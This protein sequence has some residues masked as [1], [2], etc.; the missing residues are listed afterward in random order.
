MGLMILL[1]GSISE[2]NYLSVHFK[3]VHFCLTAQ[4][5]NVAVTL[6]SF[7]DNSTI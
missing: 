7:S 1:Y 5:Y 6:K 4:G 3:N 2:E